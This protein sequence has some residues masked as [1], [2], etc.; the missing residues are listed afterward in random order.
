ML[1]T[2]GSRPPNP[3]PG[4]IPE[5]GAWALMIAGFGLVGWAARRRR[6]VHAVG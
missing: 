2:D 6:L 5:P 1:T 4:V 3:A